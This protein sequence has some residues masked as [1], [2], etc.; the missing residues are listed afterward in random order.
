ML[1]R[2]LL[3]SSCLLSSWLPLTSYAQTASGAPGFYIGVGANLLSNV[4]F[5]D[6]GIVPRLIGPALTAGVQFTPRLAGQVGLSYHSK[7]DSFTYLTAAQI[8]YVYS[9]YTYRSSYFIVP[10]LLR[11]TLTAPAQRFHVE[12]AGGATLVHARG[13][14]EGDSISPAI[15]RSSDT[16]FNL[17]LGPAVRYVLSPSLELTATSLV[18]AVVGENYYGFRDRLFLNT[19]IGVNY[20]FGKG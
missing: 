17:T 12:L 9:T 3:A 11:Y 19:A 20:T 5:N 8:G 16:R 15:G 18:S 4:P 14:F 1:S 13:L 7:K 2:I 6:Q 10:V